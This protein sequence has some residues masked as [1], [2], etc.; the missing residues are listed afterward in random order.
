MGRLFYPASASTG[1]HKLANWLCTRSTPEVRPALARQVTS[2][3]TSTVPAALRDSLCCA[4][5][6]RLPLYEVG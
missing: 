6:A 5:C 2:V 4:P 3:C 1:T